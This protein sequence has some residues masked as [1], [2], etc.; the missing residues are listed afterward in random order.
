MATKTVI[1]TIAARDM[2]EALYDIFG[3]YIIV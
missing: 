2:I 3:D 1:N